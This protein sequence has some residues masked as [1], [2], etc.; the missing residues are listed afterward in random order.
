[1]PSVMV[2]QIRDE[3]LINAEQF[4]TLGSITLFSYALMQIPFGILL[5]KIGMRRV[6]LSSIL[7]C[8]L[9]NWIASYTES[10]QLLQFARLL[11]GIGSAPALI[12]ALKLIADNIPAGSRGLLTG[13]ILTIGTLSAM[14]LGDFMAYLLTITEWRNIV[15]IF[16]WAGLAIFTL[17]FFFFHPINTATTQNEISLWQSIKEITTNRNILIYTVVAIGLFSPFAVLSDLWGT[18]FIMQKYQLDQLLATNINLKLYLGIALGSFLLPWFCE[19]HSIINKGIVFSTFIS[20]VMISLLILGSTLNSSN[21]LFLLFC[22]GFFC[23]AE[24]LCF[25]AALLHTCP[26]KSGKIAGVINTFNMLGG[27]LLA[28]TVG[29]I[30]DYNWEGLTYENGNRFYSYH[31]YEFALS[32]II[33]ILIISCTISLFVKRPKVL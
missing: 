4:A 7:L 21:L 15:S 11:I 13:L 33:I 25:T 20:C 31:E 23:G 1:M 27:A 8:S 22:I 12:C 24:M 26:S 5:D 3:F 19:K 30:L 16:N 6:L 2:S 10:F 28:Q 9:G 17:F 32:T 29:T 14:A 18:A